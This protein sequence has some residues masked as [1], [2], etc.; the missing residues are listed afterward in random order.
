MKL[1]DRLFSF[2]N[3]QMEFYYYMLFI[4]ICMISLFYLAYIFFSNKQNYSRKNNGIDE[5]DGTEKVKLIIEKFNKF[6]T[7]SRFCKDEKIAEII[8]KNSIIKP[9]FENTVLSLD[10]IV[11]LWLIFAV[12]T[13]G[14]IW[15]WLRW[16]IFLLFFGSTAVSIAGVLFWVDEQYT[17]KQKRFERH[18]SEIGLIIKQFV[19][20]NKGISVILKNLSETKDSIIAEEFTEIYNE[21]NNTNSI[22]QALNKINERYPNSLYL[23][24][25]KELLIIYVEHQRN[26]LS[27]IDTLIREIE[28]FERIKKKIEVE[29]AKQDKTIMLLV[30]FSVMAVV[31]FIGLND[32]FKAFYMS[33]IGISIAFGTTLYICMGLFII[34][35]FKIEII[36]ER[37]AKKITQ[38]EK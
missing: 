23:K 30:V 31:F 10:G 11:N 12:F 19:A 3:V 22:K 34:Q 37:K 36:K 5:K 4:L 9:K 35:Y 8:R 24:T 14:F 13:S 33:K 2:R 25:I 6:R 29:F 17:K 28:S 18:I 15:F 21:Y 38:E 20:L 32:M 26:I 7:I 16:N 27:E 1:F